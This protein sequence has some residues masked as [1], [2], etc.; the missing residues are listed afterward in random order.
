MNESL[1]EYGNEF[2]VLYWQRIYNHDHFLILHNQPIFTYLD[3]N[4]HCY[5]LW[6]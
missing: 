3:V 5:E 6:L 2:Y 1:H 4:D